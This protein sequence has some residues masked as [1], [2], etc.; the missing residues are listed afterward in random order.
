MK[1]TIFITSTLLYLKDVA[2]ATV[3]IRM[4]KDWDENLKNQSS[5]AFRR[6]QKTIIQQ[7]NESLPR[8]NEVKPIIRV[9]EFR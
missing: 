9:I 6:L 4:N 1:C 5:A 3:E 2:A 8:E 7:M